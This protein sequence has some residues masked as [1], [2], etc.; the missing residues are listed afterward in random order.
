M[1]NLHARHVH[2]SIAKLSI[3]P[4]S[5]EHNIRTRTIIRAATMGSHHAIT[6][7]I[8]S[9]Q[10]I[11]P[12]RIVMV[13]TDPITISGRNNIGTIPGA[14]SALPMRT[15]ALV[16]VRLTQTIQVGEITMISILLNDAITES[17]PLA[18]TDDQDTATIVIT[19]ITALTVNHAS[20]VGNSEVATRTETIADAM[21]AAD[22]TSVAARLKRTGETAGGIRASAQD[23]IPAILVGR[24]AHGN[25]A[26][27]MIARKAPIAQHAQ[28]TMSAMS[29][30]SASRVTTSAS[31][32]AT[33]H[34]T[35]ALT[36]TD[37]N[38]RRADPLAKDS[39]LTAASAT[40]GSTQ[41]SAMLRACRTGACSRDQDPC[42]AKKHSSGPESLRIPM[43][44]LATFRRLKPQTRRMRQEK[45]RQGS[46]RPESNL[47]RCA[48]LAHVPPARPYVRRRRIRRAGASVALSHHNA[49]LSGLHRNNSAYLLLV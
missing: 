30:M 23:P 2:A 9:R 39:T 28:H 33:L 13:A 14:S 26:R 31:R 36:L 11:P 45:L 37:P 44:S 42:S 24:A 41:K 48:S 16:L 6:G 43:I 12:H 19:A 8:S 27:R 22:R 7:A 10:D 15:M 32:D 46:N 5:R 40:I 29:A 47:P 20:T 35:N 21:S 1:N 49:A 38:A 4:G 17:D 25:S 34:Q 18:L 3:G